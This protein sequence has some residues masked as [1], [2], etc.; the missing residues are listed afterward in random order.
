MTDSSRFTDLCD[1][2]FPGARPLG[3]ELLTGG[4]S[5]T[6]TRLTL[7]LEDG[8]TRDLVLRE[9]S[10]DQNGLDAGTE[11]ALL[12]ALYEQDLPVPEALHLETSGQLLGHPFVLMAHVD[13]TTEAP[14]DQTHTFA[15]M[16]L[17]LQHIHDTPVHSLPP[18]PA[19]ND[20]RAELSEL[21]PDDP[22][23][24][25]LRRWLPDA[26][27]TAYRGVPALLHGDFWPGNLLWRDDSLVAVLDWEDAAVGDPLS[28]LAGTGLELRYLYGPEGMAEF[29][30]RY[31]GRR[32]VDP[33][34][35]ALWQAYVAAA[36]QNYMG[37]WGLPKIQEAHMRSQ[38]LA[39]LDEAARK[40]LTEA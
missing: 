4:V 10:A 3:A 21:L 23:W 13:G 12:R 2:L 16:S 24:D 28:D 7:Q 20:P 38:A 37:H 30:A 29:I 22:H 35:L 8:P 27:D 19:R 11:F 15:T 34:R 17:L 18:L 26:A 25:P 32:P 40:L 31:A 33:L 1:Y 36:A 39:M 6:V 9:H 14:G 5:A